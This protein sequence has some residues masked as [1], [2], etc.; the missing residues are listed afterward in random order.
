MDDLVVTGAL[1]LIGFY[2]AAVLLLF[3]IYSAARLM[4]ISLTAGNIGLV[5]DGTIAILIAGSF[6]LVIGCLLHKTD[7]I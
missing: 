4:Y 7:R 1:G 5:L 6:Y 2:L 3:A